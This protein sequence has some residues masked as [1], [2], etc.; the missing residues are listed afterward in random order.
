[1]VRQVPVR[2]YYV[3]TKFHG[4]LIGRFDFMISALLQDYR[5]MTYLTCRVVQKFGTII[6]YAL[7]LPNVPY[8]RLAAGRHTQAGDATDRAI[9]QW[10]RRLEC[11]VQIWRGVRTPNPPVVAPLHLV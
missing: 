8:V 7:T 5:K 3:Y 9:A 11:V 10:R 4:N 6:L 2:H 1:M